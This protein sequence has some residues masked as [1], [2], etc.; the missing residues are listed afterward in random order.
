MIE[1]KSVFLKLVSFCKY[2]F[3]IKANGILEMCP[4]AIVKY[5][6]KLELNF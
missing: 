3:K 2:A 5:D 1:G 6:R 4:H